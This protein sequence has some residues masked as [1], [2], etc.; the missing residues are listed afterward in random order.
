MQGMLKV[1]GEL[2]GASRG[3]RCINGNIY[4]CAES[5]GE[6]AVTVG[7]EMLGRDVIEGVVIVVKVEYDG[8]D[9]L[10]CI[11]PGCIGWWEQGVLCGRR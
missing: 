2:L 5:H 10:L 6:S 11:C 3:V 8:V 9:Q 4:A 7:V 1:G